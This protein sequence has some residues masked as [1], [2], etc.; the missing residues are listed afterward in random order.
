MKK[1]Q[2]KCRL[3]TDVILNSRAATEG[4]NSTLDFVPGNNFLGIVARHYEELSKEKMEM[5]IFHSG[6]VRFGDAHPVVA[7]HEKRRSVHVPAAMFYPKLKSPE[8]EC[9]IHHFYEEDPNHKMQLKQCRSGFYVFENGTGTLKRTENCSS[10]A[11]KSA[12]DRESR[13]AKDEQMYGYES[14]NA[15]QEFLF[16]VECDNDATAEKVGPLL[17]GTQRVG[18]SRTAQYGLVSIEEAKFSTHAGNVA[19]VDGI[20]AV[21]ADSRLIFLDGNGLPTFRPTPEMLGLKGTILWDKSQIRTFQYAPWNYKRKCRDTDRCGIEKGSVI[22]VQTDSTAPVESQ[23]VGSYKNEGFGHVIYNPD[24]L[25]AKDGTNGLAEYRLEK[26]SSAKKEPEPRTTDT[27]LLRFLRNRQDENDIETMN[28]VNEFVK[29]NKEKFKDPDVSF[30]SQWGTIREIA[31]HAKDE[32]LLSKK[33]FGRDIFKGKLEFDDN[34]G[35]LTHGVAEKEWNEKG[36]IDKLIDFAKENKGRLRKTLIN[37]AAEMA[38][39]K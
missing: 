15:G 4:N 30:A 12:Y 23:Y 3:L 20:I 33:L 10:F 28:K 5:E 16:E 22:V 8:E 36:R 29:A 38:K 18:R 26:E 25:K 2:F 27:P 37:L 31:S 14:I 11:V 32:S 35:Y 34:E 13:R 6:K 7:G 21:Y 24:F 39:I 19:P 17:I 9:Y 1:M